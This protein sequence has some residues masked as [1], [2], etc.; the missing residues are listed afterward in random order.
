MYKIIESKLSSVIQKHFSS[1]CK[2]IID[3]AGVFCQ[4]LFH[5]FLSTQQCISS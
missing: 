2:S 4:Q 5:Y 1:K 3:R